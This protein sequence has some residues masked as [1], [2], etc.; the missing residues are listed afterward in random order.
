MAAVL[1]AY[2]FDATLTRVIGGCAR[3]HVCGFVVV[4][5]RRTMCIKHDQHHRQT[6]APRPNS[7][8]PRCPTLS[9]WRH[10]A[11]TGLT[12]NY[13][14]HRRDEVATL[15]RAELI[16]YRQIVKDCEGLTRIPPTSVHAPSYLGCTHCM[17]SRHAERR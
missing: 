9:P 14:A 8:S 1:S 13:S 11:R 3:R 12:R 4:D 16:V 15:K 6:H 5:V 10:A 7:S 17:G 2:R